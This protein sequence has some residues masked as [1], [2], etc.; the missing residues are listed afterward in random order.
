MS[1]FDHK[2]VVTKLEFSDCL[3]ALGIAPPLDRHAIVRI[4]LGERPLNCLA[5]QLQLKW[6]PA[7]HYAGD[8]IVRASLAK[9]PP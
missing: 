6:W 5:H 2:L 8:H 7:L 9:F 4:K 1:E 3:G